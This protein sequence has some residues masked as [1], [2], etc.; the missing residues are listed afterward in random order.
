PSM[1][2]KG[3]EHAFASGRGL[4]PV[5]GAPGV[6]VEHGPISWELGPFFWLFLPSGVH[7]DWPL[8]AD[9]PLAFR[10]SAVLESKLVMEKSEPL[11]PRTFQLRFPLC[12]ASFAQR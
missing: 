1:M 5:A 9:F 11:F 8:I 2:P 6:R 10:R 7:D 4:S 3:V 12:L